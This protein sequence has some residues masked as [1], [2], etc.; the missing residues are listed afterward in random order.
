MKTD[1]L[2][3]MALL[4]FSGAVQTG[5]CKKKS[6]IQIDEIRIEYLDC[7]IN[8]NWAGLPVVIIIDKKSIWQQVVF[9]RDQDW[10]TIL[11]VTLMMQSALSACFQ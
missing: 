6:Y 9:F 10:L 4:S 5:T 11:F 3:N 7:K 1:H 8:E 2:Q